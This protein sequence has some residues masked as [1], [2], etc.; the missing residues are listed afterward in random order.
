[1][2]ETIEETSRAYKG[3]WKTSGQL[4]RG[5]EHLVQKRSIYP[6]PAFPLASLNSKGTAILLIIPGY[7]PVLTSWINTRG[8]RGIV[9]GNIFQ[10]VDEKQNNSED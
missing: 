4:P 7:L 9:L 1:M 6:V 8:G 5:F 2:I 3:S 10:H